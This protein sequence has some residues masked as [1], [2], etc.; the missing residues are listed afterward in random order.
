MYTSLG[1]NFPPKI[2]CEM[3]PRSQKFS[4]AAALC[5][6]L[7]TN[8]ENN[9]HY[10]LYYS[11]AQATCL[12]YGGTLAHQELLHQ[13]FEEGWDTTCYFGWLTGGQYGLVICLFGV[14]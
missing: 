1:A 3:A 6:V 8:P 14:S 11:S 9:A 2:F 10:Q 13:A 12:A 4:S 5:R 7:S